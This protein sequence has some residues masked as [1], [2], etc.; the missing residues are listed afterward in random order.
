MIE[1][2]S[3]YIIY[4]LIDPRFDPGDPFRIRYVGQSSR[5]LE[6]P[7]CH[8]NPASMQENTHKAKWIRK[9]CK[10]NLNYKIE[11][12]GRYS[13]IEDLNYWECYWMDYYR[14]LG[15]SLTNLKAGGSNGKPS[16]EVCQKIS[17]AKLGLKFSAQHRL[18]LSKSHLGKKPPVYAQIRSREVRGKPILCI[19]TSQVFPSIREAGKR[20][21]I[22]YSGILAVL[23][24]RYSHSGGYT[25]K[26]IREDTRI[27]FNL[28][29]YQKCKPIL[30][31]YGNI[32]P[33][34]K[35]A[36][37]YLNIDNST[38][39]EVLSKR[40]RQTKGFKFTKLDRKKVLSVISDILTI[41]TG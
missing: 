33:S 17:K 28:K 19:E 26:Y 36:S 20:L 6:R 16:K 10:L 9:L 12:L 25:F 31:Q 7:R 13:S 15:A 22:N 14:S 8:G 34:T 24:G 32:Y 29:Q 40:L 23:K 5:G 37:A 3:K 2:S 11:V 4:A 1:K 41:I 35:Y 30:D 27:Y 38:I 18:N 39:S 21:N